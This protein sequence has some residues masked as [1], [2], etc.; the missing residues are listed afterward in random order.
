MKRSQAVFGFLLTIL[1]T[2]IFLVK[3]NAIEEPSKDLANQF[4]DEKTSILLNIVFF[5]L[6]AVSYYVLQAII[7][8]IGRLYQYIASPAPNRAANDMLFIYIGNQVFI[9]GALGGLIMR[10]FYNIKTIDTETSTTFFIAV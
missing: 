4:G 8:F 2:I 9:I 7:V 6:L 1:G 10:L 5:I 3:I